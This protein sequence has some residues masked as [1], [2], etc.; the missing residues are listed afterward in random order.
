MGSARRAD[1]ECAQAPACTLSFSQTLLGCT[2]ER[3][4]RRTATNT[5]THTHKHKHTH[6]RTHMH[7]HEGVTRH[8]KLVSM[9]ENKCSR[10]GGH[11]NEPRHN[12]LNPTTT[13]TFTHTCVY[14]HTCTFTH[15]HVHSTQTRARTKQTRP[16][17]VFVVCSDAP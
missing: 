5:N 1:A 14:I 7:T 3:G 10:G 6:M 15:T 4:R 17:L 11:W 16:A 13:T 12:T 8:I 2:M 9:E